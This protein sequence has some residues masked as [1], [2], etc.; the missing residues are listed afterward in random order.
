MKLLSEA[1]L[2]LAI[3]AATLAAV[4]RLFS[5][6]PEH[7]FYYLSLITTGEASA[8]IL[9]AWSKE[10]LDSA[11]VASHDPE[12]ARKNL[13]WSYA[14]SPYMAFANEYFDEIRRVFALR[15]AM[16]E[17]NWNAEYE[18]RLRAMETAIKRL[19]ERGLFGAGAERLGI[20][21][22]VEV[23]SPD[24]TNTLRALRLNPVAALMEW[25]EEAA[26]TNFP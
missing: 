3:E 7:H 10:A 17:E 19:D 15:P 23:M 1:G 20:V 21:V 11:V 4:E 12:K 2:S 18:I 13:K 8:P 16:D 24:F 26:E 14:D 5:E 22:N 6:H 9:S 25:L